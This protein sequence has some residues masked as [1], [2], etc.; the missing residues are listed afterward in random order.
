M[1]LILNRIIGIIGVA[2][3]ELRLVVVRRVIRA[4]PENLIM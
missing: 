2:V 4:G 3:V 1:N